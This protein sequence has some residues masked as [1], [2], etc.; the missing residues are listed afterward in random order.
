M[1]FSDYSTQFE[2]TVLP[3]H[4]PATVVTV[5]S[6]LKLLRSRIG[7][8]PVDALPYARLQ[9]LFTSLSGAMMPKTV[10]NIWGS[11]HLVLNQARREGLISAVP[12]IKL[13]KNRRHEQERLTVDQMRA[14]ITAAPEPENV[15]YRLLAETGMRVGEAL[16]LTP[17]DLD[18]EKQTLTVSKSVFNG[19]LQEPKTDSAVRTMSLSTKLCSRLS[20]CSCF[21]N[22]PDSVNNGFVFR[23][24]TGRPWW[25]GDVLKTLR[26]HSIL[27]NV[28][29]MGFHAWRRGAITALADLGM[30]EPILAYRV[31]HRL[32]GLTMGLYYQ[33]DPEDLK[34]REWVEKF[35]EALK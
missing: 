31:G 2:Q 33:P 11:L 6:H 30:P 27:A 25:P 28:K 34:D 12:E 15:F 20:S 18:L 24:R 29:P 9:S 3:L 32:P 19:Q 16:A 14:I 7:D 21:V 10:R 35:A 23:T 8:L 26:N 17:A 13:P 22:T 5:R 4:K 1:T